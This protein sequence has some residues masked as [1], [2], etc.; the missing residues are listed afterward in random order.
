[1]TVNRRNER[2]RVNKEK[3]TKSSAAE[4]H[5]ARPATALCFTV[6]ANTAV[7]HT[8]HVTGGM[9]LTEAATKR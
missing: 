5:P 8:D 9:D 2:L 7:A 4:F 6:D 1:M 3:S